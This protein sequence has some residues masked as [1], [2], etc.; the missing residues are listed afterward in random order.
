MR[1]REF[2]AGL[3]SAAVWP[4]MVR[5]RF[6]SEGPARKIGLTRDVGKLSNGDDCFLP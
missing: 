3:G 1:W 5:G 6:A 4:V 2:I